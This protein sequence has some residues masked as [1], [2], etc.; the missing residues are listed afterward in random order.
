MP[1]HIVLVENLK[2]WSIDYPDVVVVTARDYLSKADFLK[3]RGASIINLCRSYR[4]LSLGYYCSLLAEPRKH[5]VI[6]TVK[7]ITDLSCRAIYSLNVEDLDAQ[8][9]KSLKKH[10]CNG[11][12]AHRFELTI[13]FGRADHAE[14][15]DLARQLFDLFR[16]PL[17]KVEFRYEGRWHIATVKPLALNA[18][19]A[20]QR[21]L[22]GIAL[23]EYLS[24]SWRTPKVKNTLRYDLAILHNPNEQTAPS[25]G[26]AL[27]KFVKA[28]KKLGVNV[29]LI[30]KK[31]YSRLAEYDALFIRE[32]TAIDHYTYHFARKARIEGMVVLDDPD[33]IVKCA[34][35]VYLAEL[36]AAHNIPSPK[37]KILQK[38]VHETAQ[39]YIDFPVVLKIPDG[40]F[41]RGVYKANDAAE[42]KALTDKLF[43]E[44]D[45]I[46]AQEFLY[47]EFDWRIGILNHQP[48]YACQYF[49]SRKHWQILKHDALGHVEEGRF[50]TWRVQDV[51][52]KVLDV[53][54][55]SAR[56]I[57][58]G[59]FG[60]DVKQTAGSV[61]VIE[62]N[63]NPNLDAG[64]EDQCLG[65]ELYATILREFQR[66]IEMRRWN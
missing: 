62:V 52:H 63:D 19:H 49:M 34:N 11:D 50:K 25:N 46:L 61:Y 30:E 20:A 39:G 55:A 47:T 58:D 18:I 16:C 56:L 29:E 3:Y 5:K 51:P 32:T 8:V 54:L 65:D 7:T 26:K 17:L 31:D 23:N 36:F 57:G 14:L 28:G 45:L 2:D 59:L 4:Y 27:Q 21:A 22:L 53:A 44:S 66:R 35:K 37:T 48:L 38:G 24:K 33:S 15:Q 1:S 42:Y 60:V 43:K 10:S 9:Q 13:F 41:S 64:I 40:S 12:D 6:P